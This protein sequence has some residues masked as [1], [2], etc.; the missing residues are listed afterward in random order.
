M[1]IDLRSFEDRDDKSMIG[2][3]FDPTEYLV[4]YLTISPRRFAKWINRQRRMEKVKQ[5]WRWEAEH[6]L[7]SCRTGAAEEV[8]KDRDE[9]ILCGW[10]NFGGF[11]VDLLAE[12]GR[13]R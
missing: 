3:E 4:A 6:R 13:R 11:Y 9:R 7:R 5:R 12:E 8:R 10:N 1:Y 2:I